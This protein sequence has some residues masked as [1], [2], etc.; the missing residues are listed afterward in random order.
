MAAVY[1]EEILYTQNIG[2]YDRLVVLGDGFTHPVQL[3]MEQYTDSTRTTLS[4]STL[5]E[6]YSTAGGFYLNRLSAGLYD[7][8]THQLSMEWDTNLS[9]TPGDNDPVIAESTTTRVIGYRLIDHYDDDVLS[10]SDRIEGFDVISGEVVFEANVL[11]VSGNDFQYE[12]IRENNALTGQLTITNGSISSVTLEEEYLVYDKDL[13]LAGDHSEVLRIVEVESITTDA[14]FERWSLVDSSGTSDAVTH[15]VDFSNEYF[16]ARYTGDDYI[17]VQRVDGFD[18]GTQDATNA[19]TLFKIPKS[20]VSSWLDACDQSNS[21]VDPTNLGSSVSSSHVYSQADLYQNLGSDDIAFLDGVFSVGNSGSGLITGYEDFDES[22]TNPN[23]NTLGGYALV[24]KASATD[25]AVHTLLTGDDILDVTPVESDDVLV[26]RT[27]E[28]NPFVIHGYLASTKTGIV[29]SVTEQE[30]QS[31]TST[32]LTSAQ[33]LALGHDNVLFE[34]TTSYS[35]KT[36]YVLGDGSNNPFQLRVKDFTDNT[37]TSLDSDRYFNLHFTGGVSGTWEARKIT[38]APAISPGDTKVNIPGF[39]EVDIFWTDNTQGVVAYFEVDEPY[40]DPKD[41]SNTVVNHTR[42]ELIDSNGDG[43]FDRFQGVENGVAAEVSQILSVANN[44]ITAEMISSNWPDDMFTG[45]FSFD[46]S[47]VNGITFTPASGD[48][49]TYHPDSTELMSDPSGQYFVDF[50][51]LNPAWDLIIDDFTSLSFDISDYSYSIVDTSYQSQIGQ[52]DFFDTDDDGVADW[53]A[54]SRQ[55][56]GA[57]EIASLTHNDFNKE[58]TL[59]YS[60]GATTSTYEL[61]VMANHHVVGWYVNNVGPATDIV[62]EW[63]SQKL[64]SSSVTSDAYVVTENETSSINMADVLATL[65]IA[66]GGNPNRGGEKVSPYQY[67]SADID[68]DGVVSAFDALNILKISAGMPSAPKVEWNF[69]AEDLDFGWTGSQYDNI[70]KASINWT[71]ID[72]SFAT[73]Q[74]QNKNLVAVLKGDVDGSWEP[75]QSS[76]QLPIGHFDNL[77][78]N[79]HIPHDQFLIA[80]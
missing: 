8:S 68:E 43:S 9:L 40:E 56:S 23:D 55:D 24:V 46:G 19:V 12:V 50:E 63:N 32:G 54:Q 13:S 72:T 26:V 47:Q 15:S 71:D 57:V 48:Y 36:I 17:Y 6:L 77:L 52:I 62:Y 34:D 51:K 70:N 38:Y 2:D 49:L 58:V 41:S 20:E 21:F 27:F 53:M 76:A 75:A 74:S 60:T 66:R 78:A 67:I 5:Y 65:D 18:D 33:M 37:K 16:F 35:N 79:E 11:T 39:G 7:P 28:S 64:L 10:P 1:S 59:T 42:V 44:M 73:A 14:W 61:A 22:Q 25:E 3:R 69:V 29:I 45:S 80:V 31:V 30:A 4:S